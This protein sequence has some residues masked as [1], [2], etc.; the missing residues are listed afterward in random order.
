MRWMLAGLSPTL[1]V[2]QR[3]ITTTQTE[4]LKM[5]G[6][7]LKKLPEGKT[8]GRLLHRLHE[9]NDENGQGGHADLSQSVAH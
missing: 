8:L 1:R 4:P 2:E 9:F 6:S 7:V 5:A 3:K